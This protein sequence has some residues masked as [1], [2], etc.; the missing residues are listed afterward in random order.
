MQARTAAKKKA[1]EQK[2]RKAKMTAKAAPKKKKGVVKV[3]DVPKVQ[4][5]QAQAEE[6]VEA[7]SI[8]YDP[9]KGEPEEVR[10]LPPPA[11]IPNYTV[12]VPQE[13]MPLIVGIEREVEKATSLKA[14]KQLAKEI[15]CK[16]ISKYRSVRDIE[17]V[18][19]AIREQVG[20][21]IG[22][23]MHQAY[24]D[25]AEGRPAEQSL[26]EL[27][28]EEMEKGQEVTTRQ[29]KSWEC[30]PAWLEDLATQEYDRDAYYKLLARHRPILDELGDDG[31]KVP[32]D[33]DLWKG[34]PA[35]RLFQDLFEVLNESA[36]DGWYYGANER[37]QGEWGFWKHYLAVPHP[38]PIEQK[39]LDERDG[40][41]SLQPIDAEF[42]IVSDDAD[43]RN[44]ESPQEAGRKK[45][46]D[47]RR[48]HSKLWAGRNG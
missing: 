18:R 32:K 4:A 42:E 44:Q 45:E 28:A 19:K 6:S 10:E 33:S 29:V 48:N 23:V 38:E 21:H 47:G 43:T 2:V 15:G 46:D 11:D 20:I 35:A 24:L 22:R 8:A 16:G 5:P 17:R 27:A 39:V 26:G 9:V 3:A 31:N 41:A 37:G 14:T 7:Q 36:P 25:R 13:H 12:N 30:V 34:E 1:R 40:G